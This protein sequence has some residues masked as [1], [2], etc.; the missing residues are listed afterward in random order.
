MSQHVTMA[1][2]QTVVSR[3]YQIAFMDWDGS[4]FVVHSFDACDDS[5]ANQYAEEHF[6]GQEWYV[7]LNGKN[8][9]GGKY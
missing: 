1:K 5:A 7:L 2:I 8:I 6:P 4:F 3:E 9:N